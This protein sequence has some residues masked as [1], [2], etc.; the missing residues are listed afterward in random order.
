[1][2]AHPLASQL[3]RPTGKLETHPSPRHFKSFGVAP[4]APDKFEDYLKD[5]EPQ[6]AL[7]VVNFI[8]GTLVSLVFL[9]TICDIMGFASWVSAWS[10]ALSGKKDKIPPYMGFRDDPMA[11]LYNAPAPRTP[12]ML[13]DRQLSG[14]RL[15]I[16]GFRFMLES[17]WS[18]PPESRSIC[19]PDELVMALRKVA[20]DDLSKNAGQ[21]GGTVPF[22]SDG[23]IVTALASRMACEEWAPLS[24]RSV[25][26]MLGVDSRSRAPTVFHQD[27]AYVQN[28]AVGAYSFG[29]STEILQTPLGQLALKYR[30]DLI[31]QMD[32]DQVIGLCRLN[33]E[34]LE[35]T[36]NAV[37]FGDLSSVVA[38]VSNWS[39]AKFLD[40]V[41]F[42]AA[43]A[44]PASEK[45]SAESGAKP[46]HPAYWQL[47]ALGSSRFSPTVF[48]VEGRDAK[49]NMWLTGDMRPSTWLKFEN[50][51]KQVM[52]R[53]S[54]NSYG[55]Q[56]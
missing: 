3:P 53:A 23:D 27:A 47:Q 55:V 35:K 22:I 48:G 19:L 33:R 1:M 20:K 56:K 39:K 46:G 10:L 31:A 13:A 52:E 26:T 4:G 36:G 49:G 9:H 14:W 41:D 28:A 2:S 25:T 8:D 42:S 12:Y 6:I 38:V 45:A 50:Y 30:N 54:V 5:D 11:Q 51:L 7:R 21:D 37:M 43:V 44:T 32:L 16:W 24:D 18:T 15:G 40:I 29:S 34:S 17:L